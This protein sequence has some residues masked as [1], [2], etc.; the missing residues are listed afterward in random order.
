MKLS[1]S[2]INEF[3]DFV[4]RCRDQK[5]KSVGTKM[6]QIRSFAYG[7]SIATKDEYLDEFC[8]LSGDHGRIIEN[9]VRSFLEKKISYLEF[10]EAIDF[11]YCDDWDDY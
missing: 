5:R 3:Y 9:N 2:L 7:L 8:W 6:D 1:Q 10:K 4:C 11:L